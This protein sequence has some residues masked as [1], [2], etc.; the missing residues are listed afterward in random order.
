MKKIANKIRELRG[1][2]SYAIAAKRLKINRETLRMLENG[3]LPARG[4][5]TKTLTWLKQATGW[6]YDEIMSLI[7]KAS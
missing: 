5:H 7:V 3:R 1:N 4:L 2:D 6:S